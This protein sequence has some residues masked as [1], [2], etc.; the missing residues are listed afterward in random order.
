MKL[1]NKKDDIQFNWPILYL[2]DP[3]GF[4]INRIKGIIEL[5]Q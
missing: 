1:E 3:S 5:K 4:Q 2:V